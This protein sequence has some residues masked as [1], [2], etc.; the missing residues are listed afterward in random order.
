MA[1]AILRVAG[2]MRG[3]SRRNQRVEATRRTE[4]VNGH[5]Y[6]VV[7]ENLAVVREKRTGRIGVVLHRGA[8]DDPTTR[9]G[10]LVLEPRWIQIQ[11]IRKSDGKPGRIEWRRYEKFEIVGQASV[12][13]LTRKTGWFSSERLVRYPRI[14]V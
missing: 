6:S 5:E 9:N 12:D 7:T 11:F 2:E 10:E 13:F 14:S 8:E 4:I 1:Y 3:E